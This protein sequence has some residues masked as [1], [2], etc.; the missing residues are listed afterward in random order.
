MFSGF[1]EEQ[2]LLEGTPQ[3]LMVG[4]VHQQA[5]HQEALRKEV[6]EYLSRDHFRIGRDGDGRY[7][8][9]ALSSNP[10]WRDRKGQRRELEKGDPPLS[11]LHGDEI[12]LFTG[13]AERTGG[14]DGGGRLLYM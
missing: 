9:V 11:L 12:L 2:R 5:L 1:S 8:L 13:A 14:L 7:H 3:G 4:R 10:I 6:R